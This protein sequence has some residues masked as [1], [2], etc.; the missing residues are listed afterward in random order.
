M[1][2]ALAMRDNFYRALITMWDSSPE[3][4]GQYTLIATL[5]NLFCYDRSIF[6]VIYLMLLVSLFWKVYCYSN[7]NIQ[8]GLMLYI[9]LVTSTILVSSKGGV[10]DTRIDVIAIILFCF[11]ILEIFNKN[12]LNALLFT[13]IAMFLKSS[14][15]FLSIPFLLYM[16]YK[17][18]INLKQ[19]TKFEYIKLGLSGVLLFVYLYKI[20]LKSIAY[21]LMSTGGEN[22]ESSLLIYFEKLYQY[23]SQDFYFYGYFLIQDPLFVGIIIYLF[24]KLLLKS[25]SI[26]NKKTIF[27]FFIF[28]IWTYFLLTSNPVHERVL[29]IWFYPVYF[30]GVLIVF[31]LIGKNKLTNMIIV[32]FL[33]VQVMSIVFQN[34]YPNE[35]KKDYYNQATNNI[36]QQVSQIVEHLNKNQKSDDILILV[37]FLSNHGPVSYNY[38]VYRVLLHEKLDQKREILGW[39]LSTYSADWRSEVSKYIKDEQII[40]FILQENP[41]GIP[42]EN[43]PQKYGQSNYN[44]LIDFKERNPEC[45]LQISDKISL[46]HVGA[47]VAYELQNTDNCIKKLKFK[48]KE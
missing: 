21:N 43:N 30:F 40:L 8:Q 12:T 46:P 34:R 19:Y 28:L 38:D 33:V 14:M 35:W 39:E 48:T 3:L 1:N 42:Q 27:A 32:S 10:L 22:A 41:M 25:T 20:L 17:N 16:S 11:A 2:Y 37:N 47:R 13:I 26:D 18:L 4:F 7:K 23:I 45:I 31:R 15:L 36:K 29:L 9:L 44:E 5:S 24:V 6:L